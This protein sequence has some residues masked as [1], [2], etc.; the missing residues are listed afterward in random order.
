[1]RTILILGD[2]AEER[3]WAEWLRG[4]ADLT[5]IVA[6]DPD[7]GLSTPNLDAAIVGG[8][9]D[10]RGEGLRRAAADG[11]AILALHPPGPNADAY[12]HVSMS[13]R[14]TGAVIVPDMPLRLHPGVARL[15]E[16]IANEELGAFRSLRLAVPASPKEDLTRVGFARVVDVVRALLGEI[17]TVTASGDPPGAAPEHELIVQLRDEQ[18]RRA[19]VR[20]STEPADAA[21]L[22]V[23]GS[24]GSL[25]LEYDPSFESPARLIRRLTASGEDQIECLDAWDPR[26]AIFGAL[27]AARGSA[28]SPS[29]LDGA[30]AMELAGAVVQSLRRGRTI[31]LHHERIDERT[32]FRAV[33]TSLG[34]LMLVGFLVVFSASLAGRALGFDWA[35]YLAYLIPPGLV[36]FVVVQ[37]LQLGIRSGET[38]REASTAKPSG[39]G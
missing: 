37:L 23:V 33:M 38:E 19:E 21:L 5:P 1:M 17:Q 12:Y 18:G 30:R 20:V 16:A 22:V 34:C 35:V 9:A 27:G 26:A 11:L 10:A 4:R 24:H 14:E 36:A 2:G 25:A 7:E 32:N 28:P 29:L 8:P 39:G 6:S 13:R 3:A 31:D 15:R